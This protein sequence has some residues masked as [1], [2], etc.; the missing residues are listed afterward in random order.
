MPEKPAA[1]QS[2]ASTNR[3]SAA[4]AFTVCLFASLC[5]VGGGGLG[6]GGGGEG[7]GGGGEGEGGGGEGGGGGGEGEGGDELNF[8]CRKR[9]TRRPP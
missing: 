1:A 3:S 6:E 5:D 4:N 9:T 2:A 7:E 8:S